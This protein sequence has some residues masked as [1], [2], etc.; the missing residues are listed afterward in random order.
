MVSEAH[1]GM[2]IGPELAETVVAAA[3][4]GGVRQLKVQPVTRNARAIRF[5][6]EMGFDILEHV[7]LCMDFGGEEGQVWRSG[8]RM[9]G[10]E[11]R[12]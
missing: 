10:R 1:R 7:E 2:G 9:A 11:F 3:R 4:Q 8:E 5:F 12:V 6:H